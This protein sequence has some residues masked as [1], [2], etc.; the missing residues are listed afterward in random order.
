M[1]F[2]IG[3]DV[4]SEP[5]APPRPSSAARRAQTYPVTTFEFG[6]QTYRIVTGNLLIFIDLYPRVGLDRSRMPTH[7][8]VSVHTS[9]LDGP[10]YRLT[11]HARRITREGIQ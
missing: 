7:I 2:G 3:K 4:H 10:K 11:G 1:I 8:W 5:R 9:L 6:A